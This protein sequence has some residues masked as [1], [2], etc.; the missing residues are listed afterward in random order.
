M[1]KLDDRLIQ[2]SRV[3]KKFSNWS[4]VFKCEPELFFMVENEDDIIKIVELAKRYNKNVRAIGAGHS[5]SDLACTDGLMINT[6]NFNKIIEI[7]LENK[8][9][10]VEAGIRLYK[11]NEEL[12]K[13]G[14]ALSNLGSISEQSIAGAISTA[15]HGSGIN[16]SNISSQVLGL[17]LLTASKGKINCSAEENED[18]FKASL[19]S[20]GALGIILKVKIQCESAFKLESNQFP[21]RFNDILND[22]DSIID[23]AEHVRFWYF[24]HTENCIIWKANKTT[25]ESKPQ[26]KNYF[27]NYIIS[28][29]LYQFLLYISRYLPS[30]LPLL[31]QKMFN[32]NFSQEKQFI[33][34]SYKQFNFDCLF[35]QYTSE[36]AIPLENTKEALEKLYDWINHNKENVFVHFPVEIRFSDKDDIWLSPSYNRKVCYIGIIMYRPYDKPVPYK[37]LWAEFEK[38]MR[39]YGGRPHWAKAHTMT[40]IEFEKTYPKFKEFIKLQK[41]LDPNGIFLN[42]YLK[43]HLFDQTDVKA[44]L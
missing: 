20:I 17:T 9:V 23:S 25:K 32:Y 22:L 19:C 8:T 18:I 38:I 3:N 44:K 4:K 40:T 1:I 30:M 39:S 29:Q 10:T 11:L 21:M 14:L 35:P 5:P 24:P 16:F 42:S 27:R 2:I 33:D 37:K 41:S 12:Q 15:T 7:D 31:N 34:D 6:D 43:R 26:E 36:W 28:Y 13:N